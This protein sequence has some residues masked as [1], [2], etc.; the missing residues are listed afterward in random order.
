[1]RIRPYIHAVDF[2]HLKKWVADE[3]VHALW[4]ARLLPFPVDESS[5]TRLIEDEG[6]NLAASP[7][8]ATDDSGIPLG[9]YM[10]SLDVFNNKGFFKFVVTDNEQ[11]GN[12]IGKEMLG[13]ALKY[14]AF[15]SGA[16]RV[17]L[18]VFGVNTPAIKLYESLGF[19]Q[20]EVI[21][22]SIQFHGENWTK[23]HM[24]INLI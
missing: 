9:F 20:D 18:N 10:Y 17:Q 12:G 23:C 2:Q 1:M 8:I 6:I 19:V 22:N 14:A 11:R 21:E 24:E 16:E 15:I 7:F 13:L 3:R 4:C 5:F